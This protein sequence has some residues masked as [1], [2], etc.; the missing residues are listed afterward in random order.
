MQPSIYILFIIKMKELTTLEKLQEFLKK[1]EEVHKKPI[2]ERTI[3]DENTLYR[4]KMMIK[5]I[6]KLYKW[7]YVYINA[8]F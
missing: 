1:A 8:E 6:D 2:N 7:E 3:E 4:E 5:I